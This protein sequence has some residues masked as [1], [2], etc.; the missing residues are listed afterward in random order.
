[1]S[2]KKHSGFTLIEVVISMLIFAII[3]LISYN[4]LQAYSTHQK[5]SFE[6]LQKIS[7]FEKT[8]LFI[9]R[10]IDQLYK[11]QID[12]SNQ[13]L[14]FDSLQNDKILSLSY[15]FTDNTLIRTHKTEDDDFELV[16]LNDITKLHFR[17][18]DDK[19][20]RHDSSKASNNRTIRA[21]ELS[22]E[23]DY[24]GKVKQLLLIQ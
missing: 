8:A 21:L 11:Q 23:N 18:L 13:I 6:H 12:L 15:A 17:L 4:A 22:F 19:N 7:N 3:S 1:M 16:L 10:D 20:N 2:I 5:L 9:K 24:W 14:S